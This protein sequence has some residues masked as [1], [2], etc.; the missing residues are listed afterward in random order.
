MSAS[1]ERTLRE[2]LP[3]FEIFGLERPLDLAKV[4]N[5]ESVIVDFGSGMGTHS[6]SLASSSPDVGVLAIDVHTVG[7]LAIAETATEKE[8]TN[9]RTHHGDGMDVFAD[10]LKPESITEVHV[11]FP[12]P[13]PKARH[14]K[15]RLISELFLD[16]VFALLKPGGR[17]VFVTDDESYFASA[18]EAI[19]ADNYQIVE[20]D[21][22][23][24]MTTY[25]QRAV[26][27]GHKVSQLSAYKN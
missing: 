6:L 25:H 20:G 5:R 10:W 1:R 15:R 24:P 23:V 26:R 27:L 8:L 3:K 18:A 2:L 17:M 16:Q 9:L 12:D 13:W 7:L 11:L 14:H 21:W 4:L 22:D 19:S